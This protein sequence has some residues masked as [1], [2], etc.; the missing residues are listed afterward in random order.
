MSA[1]FQTYS[2]LQKDE[3]V[4]FSNYRAISLLP[5]ISKLFEKVIFQLADYLKE[6]N[7]I[8]KYQYGFLKYNSTNYAALHLLAY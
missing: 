2:N 7:L 4:N 3:S 6:N 5:S 8:Y 1:Y